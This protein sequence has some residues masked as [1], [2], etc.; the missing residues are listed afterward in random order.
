MAGGLVAGVDCSTQG[1]KV[2]LVRAE[3]GALVASGRS[4]HQVEGTGGARET[5]PDVWW[6]ALHEAL[7]ETGRA[8][9]VDAI[10]VGGQQ[11]GLVT[12]DG[13]DRP[14]RSAIL[15]N[16]TRSAPDAGELVEAF[17]G[18]QRWAEEIGSVPVA[19][20][21]VTSWAWLRR[22]E[23][24]VA[25][26]VRAICL[27][28]DFLNRRLTGEATTDR[29]DASGTGWWSIRSG[30]YETGVLGLDPVGLDAAMLP[31]VLGP[32]ATAGAV[33][34]SAAEELGLSSGTVVAPGTGDNMAAALGLGLEPGMPVLSLGTSGT[35]YAVSE[36][37]PADPTGVVAGFA[38][39]TG[40]FLPLACTLNCTLAVDRMAEWLELDREAARPGDGVTV[41]PFLDG[42]RTPNLPEASGTVTGLRH[43]TRPEA[44]L[45]ATYEGAVASLLDALDRVVE[46]A[47]GLA[48]DAPLILIGG[49]AQGNV[50]RQVVSRLSGRALQ[51]PQATEL[52]ALGAAVQAAAVLGG[53]DPVAVA[54]RWD[55]RDG[56][57]VEP[58]E[59]DRETM[60][61]I[62][63]VRERADAL[64]RP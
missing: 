54:R 19:S 4:A 24:E 8:S 64:N 35:V 27:P 49:G 10:A 51:I 33:T 22:K 25:S 15:W 17:G 26:A 7:A 30:E 58:Q 50:W 28:H 12:L 40:R 63:K 2:L 44:I 3:D 16:D 32:G 18:A 11:H 38:D 5:H 37:P 41:M 59:R 31:R 1:T 34:G 57:L 23:P 56:L 13:N 20:F 14:L 61:R 46:Q 62:S 6:T 43:A 47:G 55:T 52:V 48:E 39:A 53:E 42:E 21:T 45:G 29:G 36:H 60:E 9:E